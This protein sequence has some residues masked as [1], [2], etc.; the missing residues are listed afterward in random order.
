MGEG[1]TEGEGRE[2]LAA[3]FWVEWRGAGGEPGAGGELGGGASADGGRRPRLLD[4]R[5]KRDDGAEWAELGR[6]AV[7]T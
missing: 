3:L 6:K 4:A 5:R 1:E 7:V 2:W